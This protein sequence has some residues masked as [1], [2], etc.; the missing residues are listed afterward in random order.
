SVDVDGPSCP[1]SVSDV[2][3]NAIIVSS[4]KDIIVERVDGGLEVRAHS[5]PVMAS[6]IGKDV[7]IR[8]SYNPI[9]I[10]QVGGKVN[11]DGGSC[12]VTAE[13]IAGDVNIVNSYKYVVLKRTSG[14]IIVQGSS[15]P[16]EVT[17]IRNLP[18]DGKVELITTYKPILLHLPRNADAVISAYS[19]Y[20]KISSDFPVY[21]DQG[22][23]KKIR[24]ELGEGKTTVQLKTSANITIKKD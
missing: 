11:V 3:G 4:Y 6:V 15:S 8:S 24:I 22:D 16:I 12:S 23:D 20:G 18:K 10:K 17:Q 19:R 9:Q 2:K 1:V 7:T 13:D 5:A 21:L 14:S